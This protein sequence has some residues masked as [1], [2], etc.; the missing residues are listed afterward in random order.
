MIVNCNNCCTPTNRPVRPVVCPNQCSS[1]VADG[2]VGGGVII[3]GGN[4]CNNETVLV[5][6]P[7]AMA[8]VPWQRFENLYPLQQAY[9]NGTLFRELDLEFA[10]RRCN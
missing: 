3:G 2:V 1:N 6:M 9:Q 5:G 4:A 10:G 8:Y 7:I